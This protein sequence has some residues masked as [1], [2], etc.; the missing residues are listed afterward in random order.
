MEATS[1]ADMLRRSVAKWPNKT[2]MMIP[3]GSDFRSITY[4]QLHDTV[5][6]FAGALKALGLLRGDRLALQSENCAEWSFVDWACRGL[7]I[8]VVPIYPTLPA[9]QTSYIV[10]DSG[11]KVVV[12]GSE[13]QAAKSAG[14]TVVL[15]SQLA[16][17]AESEPN[18]L[19]PEAW[20]AEIDQNTLDEVSTFIY[21]S[22]TTGNP[23]G[24]MLSNR[25]IL[26]VCYW[27][28]K[29]IDFGDVDIFL[30]FLPMSHVFE[31]VAGQALPL[32]FGGTIAYSKS[33]V[34]LANDLQKVRPTV[35][36]CVPR[37]LEATMDKI[38][39]GIKKEK[40]IKQKLFHLALA[41]G[42][43]RSEGKFAPLAGILDKLVGQKIRERVGG[44][45]KY[46]VS[47]GAALPPH[48]ARFYTAFGFVVLQGYGLTET[49]GGTFINR[50]TNNKYWTVGESL[51]MECKI[52]DDGEILLRGDGLM[53]GYFNLPEATREAVDSEGWFH[54]GDIGEFEGK[55]LKIT[56]RKKDL[57]VLANGKNIAPQLIENKLKESPLISEVVLFGDGN[58]YVYG[59]I[60]PNLERL[61]SELKE[62]GIQAPED[63]ADLVALDSV[64]SRIK[65]EID[66]VNKTLADFEK[67]KKHA[68]IAK[69]FTVESGELTPSM[70]VRRKVVKE[71]YAD[72]L[73]G[74]VR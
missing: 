32:Y 16:A 40:P 41:Q 17:S 71:R 57:L 25:N 47:G 42:T 34:T 2:A 62:A 21:T 8:V 50:P 64:R 22:G 73:A 14:K 49:S 56:D 6:A 35:L 72:V 38:L 11:A 52:A 15:L 10:Q 18:R 46:F 44:R 54:T 27:A 13:E 28:T 55:N 65:A 33:L 66:A 19:S 12:A 51:G 4:A 3:S 60:L 61:T 29:E 26:H 20:N 39:D 45:L 63:P 43:A 48:V 24:A 5:R 9:D 31:R 74:L 37:F 36:L 69:P 7:G 67:V 58:E 1:L 53:L 30:T 68:L 59:L 23:K 70:K